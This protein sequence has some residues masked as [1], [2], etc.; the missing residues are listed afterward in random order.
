MPLKPTNQLDIFFYQ[1]FCVPRVFLWSASQQGATE[2]T[3]FLL[4]H[5]SLFDCWLVSWLVS[6]LGL[7]AYQPL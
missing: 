2:L 4:P 3:S 1:T 5:R 7:M 6:W